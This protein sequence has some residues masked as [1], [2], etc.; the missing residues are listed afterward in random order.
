MRQEMNKFRVLRKGLEWKCSKREHFK[1][2]HAKRVHIGCRALLQ[3][4]NCL[5]CRPPYRNR[6]LCLDPVVVFI[7]QIPALQAVTSSRRVHN[8]REGFRVTHPS[9]VLAHTFLPTT[10]SWVSHETYLIHNRQLSPLGHHPRARCE[11][12]DHGARCPPCQA[13]A[14]PTQSGG[15]CAPAWQG[16]GVSQTAAEVH[17]EEALDS[18]DATRITRVSV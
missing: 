5:W 1:D 8:F 17:S 14:C 6:P 7:F 11:L 16:F 13:P 18:R 15:G 2:Y 12:L 3:Q 4:R 9:N 10:R